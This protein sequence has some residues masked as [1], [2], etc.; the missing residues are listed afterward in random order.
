MDTHTHTHTH[1]H[2]NTQTHMHQQ[3]HTFRCLHRNNFKNPGHVW[4]K[5]G[6]KVKKYSNNLQ[7]KE[8]WKQ[9]TGSNDIR[10]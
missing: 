3:T 7:I 10:K 5:N 4:L 8:V 2:T 9:I 6:T 1:T